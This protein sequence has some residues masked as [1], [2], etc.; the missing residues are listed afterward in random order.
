MSPWCGISSFGVLSANI[1][2]LV[3]CFKCWL[4]IG[5]DLRYIYF[6][7]K[8][9]VLKYPL[10]NPGKGVDGLRRRPGG[11][12]VEGGRPFADQVR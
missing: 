6:T 3:C 11:A 2:T 4:G 8:F 7:F 1:F 10:N 12:E 5:N 9:V